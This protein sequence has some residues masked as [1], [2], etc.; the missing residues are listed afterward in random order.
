MGSLARAYLTCRAPPLHGRSWRWQT[1]APCGTCE[2]PL[3]RDPHWQHAS[4]HACTALTARGC[5]Q[6]SVHEQTWCCRAPLPSATSTALWSRA[7]ASITGSIMP[8]QDTLLPNS[9][10]TEHQA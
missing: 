6:H 9:S 3:C 5:L 8:A 4:S 7:G 10:S 2:D 1:W